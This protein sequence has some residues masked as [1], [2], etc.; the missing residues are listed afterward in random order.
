MYV[1]LITL[2]F[3]TP[4]APEF[5]VPPALPLFFSKEACEAV[6]EPVTDEL[7]K[8]SGAK[9][10]VYNCVNVIPVNAPPA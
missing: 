4:Q 1:L 10:I 5:K 2:I 7:K 3:G 6:M 8:Q 9:G